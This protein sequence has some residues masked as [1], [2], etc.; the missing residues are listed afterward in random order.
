MRKAAIFLLFFLLGYTV[1]TTD[2]FISDYDI[3]R[4]DV[5]KYCSQMTLEDIRIVTKIENPDSGFEF[6]FISLKSAKT[7]PDPYTGYTTY[8]G[9]DYPFNG[10]FPEGIFMQKYFTLHPDKSNQ[11]DYNNNIQDY[12]DLLMKNGI[13]IQGGNS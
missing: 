11:D 6:T 13:Y 1:S 9:V 7:F 4:A 10:E 2:E 3:Y 8:C 5:Q 12:Y